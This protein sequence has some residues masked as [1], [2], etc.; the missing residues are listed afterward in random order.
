MFGSKEYLPTQKLSITASWLDNN[1]PTELY[2][3]AIPAKKLL[4][5]PTVSVYLA[6]S[7]KNISYHFSSFPVHSVYYNAS[8]CKIQ[9]Q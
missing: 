2:L 6:A 5:T 9:A 1:L 4:I 3:P 8:T 7:A